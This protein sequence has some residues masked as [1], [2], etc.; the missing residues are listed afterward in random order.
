MKAGIY[1][2]LSHTCIVPDAAVIYS[3]T[4]FVHILNAWLD[5][6]IMLILE[7]S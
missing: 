4:F 7:I 2:H 3:N 5:G 6:L 1:S